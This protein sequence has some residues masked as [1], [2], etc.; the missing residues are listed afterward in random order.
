MQFQS[1]FRAVSAIDWPIVVFL[2]NICINLYKLFKLV[3]I[4]MLNIWKISNSKLWQFSNSRA[5]SVQFQS[6]FS[7][8]SEQFQQLIGQSTYYWSK[9]VR[10]SGFFG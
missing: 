2:V 10:I 6:S 4:Q 5:V 1:S 7:A 3:D 8:I 9:L